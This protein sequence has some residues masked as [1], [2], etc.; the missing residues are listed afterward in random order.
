MT[1][2][3][4]SI[5]ALAMVVA[6]VPLSITTSA[7]QVNCRVPFSFILSGR[8]LPPGQYS[9]STHQ[10]YMMLTGMQSAA[11]SLALTG[12]DTADGQ[13]RLVFLKTGERYDLIEVWSGDGSG[14][15][16]PAKRGVDRRLASSAPAERVV[17]LGDVAGGTR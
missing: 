4:L 15:Q 12:K 3:I 10:G 13:A 16:I 9:I 5:V 8:T 14:L 11:I 6:I 7:S 1:K 17:V 2:R